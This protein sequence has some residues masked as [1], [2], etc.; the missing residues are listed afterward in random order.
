MKI[1]KRYLVALVIFILLLIAVL[2]FWFNLSPQL[3]KVEKKVVE[4]GN[5]IK[6]IPKV[7]IP[8][9]IRINR[10]AS[11]IPLTQAGVIKYTN[12][13]REKNGLSPL[14]ENTKLDSSAKIKVEDMFSQQYFAHQS[15]S[16]LGVSDLAKNAGYDFIAIGENM[17]L[18]NFNDD[19]AL[20]EAWMQ[21]PGHRE[22]ILNSKYQ[23]IGV[24]VINGTYEG[25]TTWIAVQ[26]FG[27]PAS[28]CLEVS[29][30]LR[31]TID[32]NQTKLQEMLA[33][34]KT[35]E[36]N[37][38]NGNTEQENYRILVGQ[39][40]NLVDENKKMINQYNQQV[41]IYNACLSGAK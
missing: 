37:L 30:T 29:Q 34:I 17:A 5:Q 41:Q 35:M 9:P 31:S 27:M 40:N 28:A 16:G 24:S 36:S 25:E 1:K 21:S 23:E 19:Q 15:P 22:N 14:K 12:L 11:Q 32:T 13:A 20:V 39:Y 33:Q 6:N 38:N 8:A 18:G 3:P 2:F 4:Q 26:H 7:L 10:P